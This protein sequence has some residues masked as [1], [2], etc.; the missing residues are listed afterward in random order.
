[1]ADHPHLVMLAGPNGAGKST[2]APALLAGT[3]E[4]TEFVNADVIARGLS[5]FRPED[6]AVEAGRIMLERLRFLA[7]LQASFAFET[8]LASRSFA[9][10]IADL[11]LKNYVFHLIFLYLPSPEAAIARVA[12]RVRAGGHDVPVETIRRRYS[13]GLRNF[14]HLYRP[15]T[16][17]WRFYENTNSSGPQLIAK[18]ALSRWRKWPSLKP[19]RVFARNGGRREGNGQD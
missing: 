5:A 4:L 2:A 14:F 8:T 16:D 19:G 18:A 11:R 7:A 17:W 12:E 10:W 9:P 15:L 6:V 13:A 3:L 1:V